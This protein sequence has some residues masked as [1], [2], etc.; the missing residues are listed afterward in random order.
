MD[1]RDEI[2]TRLVEECKNKTYSVQSM[3]EAHDSLYTMTEGMVRLWDED[4]LILMLK[5]IAI[6]FDAGYYAGRYE[7]YEPKRKGA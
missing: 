5:M 4:H 7:V 3:M 1:K 2:M 6:S